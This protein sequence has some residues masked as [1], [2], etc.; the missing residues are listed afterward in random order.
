MSE[1]A[2]GTPVVD[3]CGHAS[4]NA[5]MYSLVIA[6]DEPAIRK[7]LT[8]R[9]DWSSMGFQVV[10]SFEDGEDVVA[11]LSNHHVDVVLTDVR[12]SVVSGLSLAQRIHEQGLD[13]DVVLLSGY[14]DFEYAREA[15]KHGVHR[16]L[17]KPT[18][19]DELRTVFAELRE[20]IAARRRTAAPGR[21]GRLVSE[22]RQR[23][24]ARLVDGLFEGSD[25]LVEQW[26]R[27]ALPPLSGD[28]AAS[29]ALVRIADPQDA[30]GDPGAAWPAVL[31]EQ[32][33]RLC[34]DEPTRA[35]VALVEPP[36]L[37]HFLVVA[38][39]ASRTGP[40]DDGAPD[41]AT[42]LRETA[43][44]RIE[45]AGRAIA[46][47]VTSCAVGCMDDL[48]ELPAFE[49]DRPAPSAARDPEA[50]AR[51]LLDSPADRV[52]SVAAD[53]GR[54]IASAGT[55]PRSARR[56]AIAVVS[57]LVALCRHRA[58]GHAID[59]DVN[60]EALFRCATA[61]EAG[62]WAVTAV[63]RILATFHEP[64][65]GSHAN[66]VARVRSYIVGHLS[67][68]I[69]LEHV[70]REVYLSPA[71]LSRLFHEE[72]GQTFL[73]AVTEAR[74]ERAC[75]LLAERSDLPVS[76]VSREVGY[77]DPKYFARVFKSRMGRTPSDYRRK[78]ALS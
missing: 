13:T 27:C 40:A 72:A 2:R 62:S 45:G 19:E 54:E 14:K 43:A 17:L 35:T 61:E 1:A 49:R 9:I 5:G 55:R 46:G 28:V 74:V 36:D 53:A 15:L 78:L 24:L 44:T 67:E 10:E 37:L 29:Y 23:L 6:D 25:E 11:Y 60:Y 26:R 52:E 70:A 71:Y 65:T 4:Y 58:P 76:S 33:H 7:G 50:I 64:V 20:K 3:S 41:A 34:L 16:Y 31:H 30:G 66:V 73:D 63:R 32:S 8:R 57:A 51:D 77:S 12:M 47:V 68:D 39:E 69:G 38:R 75:T 56:A 59:P 21:I 42:V 22:G 18:N 48:L